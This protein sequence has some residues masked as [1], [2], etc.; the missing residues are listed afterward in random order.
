V[1]AAGSSTRFGDSKML[2]LCDGRPLVQ[3]VTEAAQAATPQRVLIV[4]GR[5]SADVV[6]ACGD[7]ADLVVFNPNFERGIGT[8]IARGVSALGPEV[9][10]VIIALA[11]QILV[12]A[13]H[14]RNLLRAWSGDANANVATRFGN[15]MGPPALFGR[16]AIMQLAKLNADEGALAILQ[17]ASSSLS[18]VTFN[19]A[20]LDID[21]PADLAAF[22]KAR[23]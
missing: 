23:L 4:T 3:I 2:T 7:R 19:A 9:T 22:G 6:A 16:D 8:S 12:D 15:R 21:T 17:D 14:L 13:E 18:E 1:L 5:D 10:G 20:A 11:D